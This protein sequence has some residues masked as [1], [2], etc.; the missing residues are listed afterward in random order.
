MNSISS[1][2]RRYRLVAIITLTIALALAEVA[3]P[4]YWIYGAAMS[5]FVQII[6]VSVIAITLIAATFV[7]WAVVIAARTEGPGGLRAL[8]RTIFQWL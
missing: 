4:L 7:I 3:V 8:L 5:P 1:F 2:V 6:F